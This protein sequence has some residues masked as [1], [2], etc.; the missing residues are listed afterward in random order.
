MGDEEKRDQVDAA[1]SISYNR[2][3]GGTVDWGPKDP[4]PEQPKP[5]EPQEPAEP[6]NPAD[7]VDPGFS[8][9]PEP[10]EPVESTD[11]VVPEEP[12]GPEEPESGDTEA[13]ADPDGKEPDPEPEEPAGSGETE[14]KDP[15]SGIDP[16]G[17]FDGDQG[18]N[19][20][21]TGG[22]DQKTEVPVEPP[23]KEPE[24]DPEPE[25][26]PEPQ[27]DPEL[28]PEEPAPEAPKGDTTVDVDVNHSV[29]VTHDV[30]V[31]VNEG[32]TITVNDGS[33]T[34]GDVIVSDDSVTVG[35]V[36]I[37]KS[38][39][40][41]VN[42]QHVEIGDVDKSVTQVTVDKSSSTEEHRDSHDVYDSRDD[43]STHIVKEG[44]VTT[45]TDSSRGDVS[46]TTNVNNIT[47]IINQAAPEAPKPDE[48]APEEPAVTEPGTV[49]ANPGKPVVAEPESE[50]DKTPAKQPT[51][52]ATLA[53]PDAT[54][55]PEPVVEEPKADEKCRDFFQELMDIAAYRFHFPVNKMAEFLGMTDALTEAGYI[56][57]DHKNEEMRNA[58]L[59]DGISSRLYMELTEGG[60]AVGVALEPGTNGAQSGEAHYAVDYDGV[61]ARYEAIFGN[62][63]G[64]PSGDGYYDALKAN[65]ASMA[66][67][68]DA[69]EAAGR[70]YDPVSTLDGL[71][72]RPI[73]GLRPDRVKLLLAKLPEDQREAG[74]K[75]L[76]DMDAANMTRY[77]ADTANYS[78]EAGK[79]EVEVATEVYSNLASKSET[80]MT[81]LTDI[82][83][84]RS[85]DALTEGYIDLGKA[86]FTKTAEEFQAAYPDI[87]AAFG[88]D[89]TSV[90][91]IDWAERAKELAGA[92]TGIGAL[93]PEALGI[94]D[95]FKA[96][97]VLSAVYTGSMA[98]IVK[99]NMG[100][101][102][103]NQGPEVEQAASYDT[104][105]RYPWTDTNDIM[106]SGSNVPTT[107]IK[108]WEKREQARREA[109]EAEH[110][111]YVAEA[112]QQGM[113]D[114]SVVAG[115]EGPSKE[116][117]KETSEALAKMRAQ[118]AE[119]TLGTTGADAQ[120]EGTEGPD[121][122]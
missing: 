66:A 36:S 76:V 100:L 87:V 24:P 44:D 48:P 38:Q 80:L 64:A 107:A 122:T 54:P 22:T 20:E 50:T 61:K 96:Y 28:E 97:S 106:P 7:D 120:N 84:V 98:K 15:D 23:V 47:Y 92:A 89:A 93:E 1:E 58:Y 31:T 39:S 116:S 4:E 82:T 118:Q 71:T 43:H 111:P 112:A 113:V 63:E 27:P 78:T 90:G 33:Q 119:Q 86:E 52:Q 108:E 8:V 49:D 91:S 95:R 70:E 103:S 29:D 16:D 72:D 121:M 68:H 73:M 6:D 14:P 42:D 104:Q 109:W 55:K 13:P 101:E 32:D 10:T 79:H 19:Q 5:E 99:E 12:K 3:Q 37:D 83:E 11:P 65:M 26:K 85:L 105:G 77:Q 60:T 81:S 115:R 46:Y 40:T 53:A 9:D 94:A 69:A 41:T 88:V 56:I 74:L 17:W 110:G 102:T 75:A 25:P 62:I 18:G 114:Q 30:D 51:A 59:N 2:P 67:G 117:L 35:D 21:V 34:V 57:P 45:I